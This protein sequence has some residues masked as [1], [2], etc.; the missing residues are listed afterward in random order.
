MGDHWLGVIHVLYP[1]MVSEQQLPCIKERSTF[2]LSREEQAQYTYL[3][4]LNARE[5]ALISD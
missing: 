2:S 3:L 1:P 4:G 5:C